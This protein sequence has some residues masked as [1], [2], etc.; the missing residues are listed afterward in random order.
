MLPEIN[1]MLRT[2]KLYES[3]LNER[4]P[5][6][7]VQFSLDRTEK[8]PKANVTKEKPSPKNMDT[9]PCAVEPCF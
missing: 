4:R 6:E 8:T 3:Q 2:E 5:F 1:L 9:R 7:H